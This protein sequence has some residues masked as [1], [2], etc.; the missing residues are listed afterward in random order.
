MVMDLN[1]L[2]TKHVCADRQ[3]FWL[4][5]CFRLTVRYVLRVISNVVPLALRMSFLFFSRFFRCCVKHVE[6]S[7]VL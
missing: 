1:A 5:M 6:Y 2:A 4:Q 7:K 3:V